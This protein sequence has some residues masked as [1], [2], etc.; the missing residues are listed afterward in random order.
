MSEYTGAGVD[1]DVIAREA[2][3]LKNR[4]TT[5]TDPDVNWFEWKPG[6]N[7]L[8]LLPPWSL[9][10]PDAVE[11]GRVVKKVYIHD[12]L[13]IPR[14][15]FPCFRLSF[16]GQIKECAICD[17]LMN[18]KGLGYDV[19]EKESRVV[20][21]AN[22]L[23][24]ANPSKGAQV[25][26]LAPSDIYGKLILEMEK[27]KKLA[28]IEIVDPTKGLDLLITVKKGDNDA[29]RYDFNVEQATSPISTD[30]NE[31]D[32]I[33]RSVYNL[34]QVV[35]R[36]KICPNPTEALLNEAKSVAA[37]LKTV[38]GKSNYNPPPQSPAPTPQV[39]SAPSPNDMMKK[40]WCFGTAGILGNDEYGPTK[41]KCMQCK[42][43]TACS[44]IVLSLKEKASQSGKPLVEYVKAM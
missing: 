42:F 41:Q 33:L 16:P 8:R 13:G 18:L 19:G 34:D 30:P 39:S 11:K 23:E 12:R 3:D 43:D 17:V 21:F 20:I 2:A 40:P 27:L 32:K 6:L 44:D 25:T 28:N 31:S 10:H 35:I 9:Y 7:R 37:D 22:I 4:T 15:K 26:R 14:K 5:K 1:Y 29:P 36:F 24:R 38:I